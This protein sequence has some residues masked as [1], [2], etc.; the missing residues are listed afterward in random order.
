NA[1]NNHTNLSDD[2]LSQMGFTEINQGSSS[3]R[4]AD[5]NADELEGNVLILAAKT[6]SS[7]DEFKIKHLNVQVK[8]SVCESDGHTASLGDYVWVDVNGDGQQDEAN[9]G[10]NGVTVHLLDK[11]GKVIDTTVTIDNAGKAGYYLFDN[12]A[13]GD[14]SVEFVAPGGYSF[15]QQDQGSDLSDSDANIATGRTITTTLISGDN[16]LSWDAGLVAD[17]QNNASLGDKVWLDKDCDGIQGENEVGVAGV[18][19][20]L[21]DGSGATLSTTSTDA[22]GEYLFTDLVPGTYSV[23]FTS[24]TGYIFTKQD[25]TADDVDSDANANGLT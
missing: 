6:S 17:V 9:T 19:V 10:L 8:E 12:L 1:F 22:A 7:N 5:L 21:L 16:D 15:T 24:P 2:I 23:S 13:P 3:T 18:T 4:L 11:D 14:Y 25:A 20:S